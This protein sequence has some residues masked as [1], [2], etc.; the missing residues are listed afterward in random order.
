MGTCPLF[1]D[2][3]LEVFKKVAPV[4]TIENRLG[5]NR[6]N[7]FVLFQQAAETDA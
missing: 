4:C 5:D 7:V 3:K 1:E 6:L 2:D